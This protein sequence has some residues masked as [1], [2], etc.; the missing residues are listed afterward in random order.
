MEGLSKSIVHRSSGKGKSK[1]AMNFQYTSTG[2]LFENAYGVLRGKVILIA[3]G[4]VLTAVSTSRA[5]GI[6]DNGNIYML[7]PGTLCGW[8]VC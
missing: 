1:P 6:T 8:A 7:S 5:V 2:V 4:I 3:W